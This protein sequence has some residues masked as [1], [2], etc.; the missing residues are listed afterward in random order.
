MARALSISGVGDV[1]RHSNPSPALATPSALTAMP[2]GR[3]RNTKRSTGIAS[4]TSLASTTPRMGRSGQASSHDTRLA[5]PAGSWAMR[6][7]WRSARSALTSRM[8]YAS[9]SASSAASSVSTSA[10]M[11]PDPA[12]ISSTPPPVSASMSAAWRARQRENRL[13][14]SGAVVK[15][16]AAPSFVAPAL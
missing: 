14:T 12:P 13:E 9:G 4:S 1:S 11:R 6:A 16:P 15:S 2:S 5:R 10:A 7:R 3:P 8:R